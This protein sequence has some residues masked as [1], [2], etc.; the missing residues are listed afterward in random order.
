MAWAKTQSAIL[1]RFAWQAGRSRVGRLPARGPRTDCSIGVCIRQSLR[2]RIPLGR[3]VPIPNDLRGQRLLQWSVLVV[4]LHQYVRRKLLCGDSVHQVQGLLPAAERRRQDLWNVLPDGHGVRLQDQE[5]S[6]YVVQATMVPSPRRT[7]AVGMTNSNRLLLL[8]PD[9]LWFRDAGRSV[10]ISDESTTAFATAPGT[11]KVA[12]IRSV[13]SASVELSDLTGGARDL[14]YETDNVLT[15]PAWGP[16]PTSVTVIELWPDGHGEIIVIDAQSG[17]THRLQPFAEPYAV[18]EPE[19]SPDGRR[20]AFEAQPIGHPRGMTV[21]LWNTVDESLVL[22]DPLDQPEPK[23]ACPHL[24]PRGRALVYAY[25]DAGVVGSEVR[26]ID[27]QTGA[28]RTLARGGFNDPRWSTSGRAIL[29]VRHRTICETSLVLVDA[30]SGATETLVHEGGHHTP[31]HL[32]EGAAVYIERFCHGVDYL[33]TA[34]GILWEVDRLT[35]STRRLAEDVQ[36]A[37]VVA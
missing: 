27:L 33:A 32:N 34:P 10:A 22:V 11:G 4:V 1:H 7:C 17:R 31:V 15:C 36:A 19:W 20:L 16:G 14:L 2:R 18:A 12:V 9:G 25:A 8:G 24:D 13:A 5:L 21:F 30:G 6:D 29:A 26:T 35:H 3:G 23:S 37:R 28:R